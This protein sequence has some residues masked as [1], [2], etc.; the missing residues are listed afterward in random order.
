MLG[1]AATVCGFRLA[2]LSGRVVVSSAEALAALAEL[3][4]AGAS[5]ILLTETVCD[6][7]G[8]LSTLIGEQVRPVVVVIP[9]ATPPRAERS[10]AEQVARAVRRAL[11]IPE[12]QG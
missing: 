2:G 12:P 1:D 3:R 4:A 5:L 10:P 6:A 9:A 11:S 7:L 8:G